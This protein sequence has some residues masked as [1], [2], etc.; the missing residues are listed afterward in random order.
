MEHIYL[1]YNFNYS[2][3]F[4]IECKPHEAGALPYLQSLEYSPAES[5]PSVIFVQ[6]MLNKHA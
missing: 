3:P 6:R 1:F 2:L 4:S 5:R